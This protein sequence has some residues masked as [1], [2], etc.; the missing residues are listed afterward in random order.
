ML[1][2]L[3]YNEKDTSAMVIETCLKVRLRQGFLEVSELN[4]G[5]YLIRL[6]RSSPIQLL[7]ISEDKYI[8]LCMIVPFVSLLSYVPQP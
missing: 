3:A 4:S 1:S 2:A 6:L 8:F 7:K 5:S